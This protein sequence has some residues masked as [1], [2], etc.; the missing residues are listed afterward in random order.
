[1]NIEQTILVEDFILSDIELS[2]IKNYESIPMVEKWLTC[3]D[4]EAEKASHEGSPV[5]MTH[6]GNWYG[7]LRG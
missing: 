1:M 4:T 2:D 7:V 6:A 5:V 3:S